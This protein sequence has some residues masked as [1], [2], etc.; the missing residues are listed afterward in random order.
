MS[1][2]AFSGGL[3]GAHPKYRASGAGASPALAARFDSSAQ[4]HDFSGYTPYRRKAVCHYR[5]GRHR[6]RMQ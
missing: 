3:R 6:F 5:I 1:G 2:T 4:A